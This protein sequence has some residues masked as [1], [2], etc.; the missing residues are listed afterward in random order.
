MIMQ[1][2]TSPCWM[3][4]EHHDDSQKPMQM[5]ESE[6]DR[7]EKQKLLALTLSSNVE[8]KERF[9]QILYVFLKPFNRS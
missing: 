8:R 3:T 9:C 4:R 1:K 5:S 2:Y 7:S 6:T